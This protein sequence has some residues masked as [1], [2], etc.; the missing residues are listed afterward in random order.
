MILQNEIECK[1]CGDR[2][3]SANRHDFKTC[4]CGAVSVDGGMSYLRRVGNRDDWLDFSIEIPDEAYKA[5]IEN[6][7]WAKE[8]GRNELGVLCAVVRALRD[9]GV[10]IVTHENS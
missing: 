1:K 3:F 5:A 4:K 10:K 9:N 2:I 6:I 8:T 7:K